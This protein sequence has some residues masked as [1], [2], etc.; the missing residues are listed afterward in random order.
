[1][2]HGQATIVPMN[3]VRLSDQAVQD[4]RDDLDHPAA[5]RVA[6]STWRIVHGTR[7]LGWVRYLAAGEQPFALYYDGTN[8]HGQQAWCR[9]FTS[10]QRACAWAIQ[11]AGDIRRSTRELGSS[12]VTLHVADEPGLSR[13]G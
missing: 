11:H 1:M 10:F 6:V 4:W 3:K 12:I 9:S 13:P 5:T 8:E 2:S 7:T